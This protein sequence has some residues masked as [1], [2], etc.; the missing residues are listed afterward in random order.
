MAND[1][2]NSVLAT[3]IY[4]DGFGLPLTQ[5]EIFKYLVNSARFYDHNR[6]FPGVTPSDI[7][8]EVERLEK[9]GNIG[10]RNGFYF[11]SGKDSLYDQRL[12]RQKT[13]DDKWRKFLNKVKWLQASPFLKAVFASGSL[14]ANNTTERSD[15]DVLTITKSGRLY[16]ARLFLWLIS[17]IFLVRRGR[18]DLVAPDK[19]CFNHYLTEKS[20]TLNHRSL[21]VA[22]SLANIKPVIWREEEIIKNF[23]KQNHWVGEYVVNYHAIDEYRNAKKMPIMIAFA[24]AGEFLLGGKFGDLVERGLRAYQQRRIRKNPATYESGGRVIFNNG[25]LEFHP[26]SFETFVISNYNKTVKKL[27]IISNGE[28]DSGLA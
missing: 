17:S 15:F 28:S 12:A 11:L 18:Y 19:L 23:Y 4:Y 9:A 22:Q 21:F 14:A 8:M 25:E 10:S 6:N 5:A 24:K 20:L 13:A 7:A 16:T 1:I 26:R 2:K 3:I 27:G